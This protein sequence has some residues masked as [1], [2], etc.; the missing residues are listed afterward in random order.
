M[1]NVF[2]CVGGCLKRRAFAQ[3]E[4]RPLPAWVGSFQF[5][6]TAGT[7]AIEKAG[8]IRELRYG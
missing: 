2:F 4:D 3:P 1:R 5:N 8:L 7:G 6:S